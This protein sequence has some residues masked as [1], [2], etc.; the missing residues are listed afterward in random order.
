VSGAAA[1]G[2]PVP[3]AAVGA[4]WCQLVSAVAVGQLVRDVVAGR[5]VPVRC[6]PV[7]P[8]YRRILDWVAILGALCRL[9]KAMHDF[10]YSLA[11]YLRW[12]RA[13]AGANAITGHRIGPPRARFHD[14]IG[15]VHEQELNRRET[16][17]EGPAL[18]SA[19][20]LTMSIILVTLG[21]YNLPHYG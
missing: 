7:S 4:S 5:V 15:A 21:S 9:E 16:R 8:P 6:C 13:G 10:R 19:F 2:R 12:Y 17:P 14:A 3:V 11:I 20:A 1:V 18:S